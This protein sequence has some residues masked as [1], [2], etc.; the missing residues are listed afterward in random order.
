MESLSKVVEKAGKR[1][2]MMATGTTE[3]PKKFVTEMLKYPE[4]KARFNSLFLPLR[5]LLIMTKV[6]NPIRVR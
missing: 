6:E 1:K 5:K 2:K 4:A 3:K